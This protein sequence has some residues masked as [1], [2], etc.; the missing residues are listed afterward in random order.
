MRGVPPHD[1]RGA[2]VLLREADRKTVRTYLEDCEKRAVDESDKFLVWCALYLFDELEKTEDS[3][4]TALGEPKG[5]PCRGDVAKAEPEKKA[6]G[7]CHSD[8]G[9]GACWYCGGRPG[10]AG[11]AYWTQ[12]CEKRLRGER[13]PV[14]GDEDHAFDCR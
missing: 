5:P 4:R 9:G 13:C 10:K 12:L 14:C 1:R 3:L 2:Y 11:A 7:P 8:Y 6:V